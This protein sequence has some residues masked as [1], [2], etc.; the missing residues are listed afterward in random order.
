[1]HAEKI[2]VLLETKWEKMAYEVRNQ[3]ISGA[4]LVEL[5]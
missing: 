5:E 3:T 2:L 4:K 1:M